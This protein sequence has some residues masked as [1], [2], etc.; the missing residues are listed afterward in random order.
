M[1]ST[2]NAYAQKDFCEKFRISVEDYHRMGEIGIFDHQ[3][4]VELIDGE[5]LVRSP[6]SPYHNSHVDKV[7]QFF[8]SRLTGK[9][10]I[11]T[12]GSVRLD[13]YSEPEPDISILKFREN[14]YS[15][16]Q[17]GP[18]DILLMV[19]VS[20]ETLAKDRTL[21][22][23]KYARSGIP[24]YWI[25]IPEEEIVEVYRR[26]KD[27]AYQE[28]NTYGKGDTWQFKAFNLEVKGSDLL[29]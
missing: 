20:L 22:L 17:P 10:N 13:N 29:I 3:P 15:D 24:E 25:V 1:N 28:K 7:A 12:Q 4:R 2:S 5:I 26:P 19:E 27:G 21:K 8:F 6:I 11:R 18:E 23:E 16:R 9:A 14:F